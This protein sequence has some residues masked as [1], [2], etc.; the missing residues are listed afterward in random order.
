MR[1]RD[2]LDGNA[3]PYMYFRMSARWAGVRLECL[4]CLL[5]FL[6]HMLVVMYHGEIDSST[7]GL[8]ISY[9]VMVGAILHCRVALKNTFLGDSVLKNVDMFDIF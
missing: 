5:A 9:T 8:A 1:F 3:L 4:V 6:T 7:A 2:L